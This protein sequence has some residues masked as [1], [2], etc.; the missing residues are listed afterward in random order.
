MAAVLKSYCKK[1]K[2]KE[3]I[4]RDFKNFPHRQFQREIVK[5]LNENN[6]GASQFVLFQT[7]SLGLLN[8][9]ETSK[10]KTLRKKQL[11]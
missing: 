3:L 6:V 5:E 9:Y 1:L 2:P 10:K 4:Y 11:Q 7:V 8:K